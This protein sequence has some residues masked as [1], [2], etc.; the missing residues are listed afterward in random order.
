MEGKSLIV[1]YSWVGNTAVVAEEIQRV[2]GFNT[3]RIFEK[4]NGNSEV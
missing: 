1:Y 4:S 3:L 2:T